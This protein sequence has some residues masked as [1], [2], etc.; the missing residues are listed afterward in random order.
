MITI[1]KTSLKKINKNHTIPFLKSQKLAKKSLKVKIFRVY[2]VPLQTC[3]K[4]I[5][6]LVEKKCKHFFMIIYISCE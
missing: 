5:L 3:L 4:R 1:L 6:I 2:F